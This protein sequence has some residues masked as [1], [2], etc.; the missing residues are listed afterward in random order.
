MSCGDLRSL[1]WHTT[2]ANIELVQ[3]RDE[4]RSWTSEFQLPDGSCQGDRS[5][6]RNEMAC[7][8]SCPHAKATGL[9]KL[10]CQPENRHPLGNDWFEADLGSAVGTPRREACKSLYKNVPEGLAS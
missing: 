7:E 1:D 10:A 2:F 9:S 4:D 5:V 8:M 3:R 6:N